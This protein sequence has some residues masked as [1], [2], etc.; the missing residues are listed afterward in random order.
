MWT[1]SK[2]PEASVVFDGVDRDDFRTI[3]KKKTTKLDDV[4]LSLPRTKIGSVLF[5]S[6]PLTPPT[7]LGSGQRSQRKRRSEANAW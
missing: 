5:V 3:G 6:Q 4:V 2:F 1:D 7:G